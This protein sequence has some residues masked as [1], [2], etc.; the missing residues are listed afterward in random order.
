M[1]CGLDSKT[2]A[3]SCKSRFCLRCGRISAAGFVEEIREKLH[4]GV[5]YRHV[6][7]TIPEQLRVMFYENRQSSEL[8]EAFF[9]SGWSCL[10]EVLNLA[11]RCELRCGC[12]MVIHVVGRK[13]DYKPHLHILLMDGGIDKKSGE[14]VELGYFPYSLLHKKWQYHLLKM[15][16]EFS[17][18]E[19]TK[20]LVDQLWKKYPNGFVGQIL[21]G[22][23]PKRM[24]K[25]TKYLSKYLF[26]PSI[27]ARR[28]KSY[29]RSKGE[30]VYEYSSHRTKRMELETVGVLIFL[31][32]MAQQILPK[33][34]QR[35]RYYGL[36]ATASYRK[37]KER[38][39]EAMT[40]IRQSPDYEEDHEVF[41][42]E[43]DAKRSKSSYADRILELTG[44]DPLQCSHCGTRMEVVQVWYFKKGVIVDLL[45]KL[46]KS[47][48][49]PPVKPKIIRPI[50]QIIQEVSSQL[51]LA[52]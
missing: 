13:G 46:K 39:Q 2:V 12:L 52:L 14:W 17:P 43:G 8:F 36:Q 40:K 25:L 42:Q 31:G 45:E 19:E 1:K 35:V 44:R 41:Y 11:T 37:S 10:Q 26:R 16:K 24:S 20:E 33:G 23:V 30:V 32:R 15:V 21:K 6:I 18:T 50:V 4:P 38:I 48:T 27:S 29:D 7:L 28:I 34:F 49:G 3:F 9:H 22:E 5:S 51:Q 47:A